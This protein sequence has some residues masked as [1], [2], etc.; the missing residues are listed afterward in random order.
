MIGYDWCNSA[1]RIPMYLETITVKRAFIAL[2]TLLYKPWEDAE[3]RELYQKTFEQNGKPLQIFSKPS[4]PGR[5]LMQDTTR[6]SMLCTHKYN[7]ISSLI[8]PFITRDITAVYAQSVL[9]NSPRNRYE[10][11]TA[12]LGPNREFV[13]LQGST[14]QSQNTSK[15]DEVGDVDEGKCPCCGQTGHLVECDGCQKWYH[16]A[17]AGLLM[18]PPSPQPKC[19]SG[20]DPK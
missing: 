4:Q 11:M 8:C 6:G 17:C 10:A 19:T 15:S 2:S 7:E 20:A 12:L 1:D 14:C 13:P 9:C 18:T 5:Y 3:A 16:A